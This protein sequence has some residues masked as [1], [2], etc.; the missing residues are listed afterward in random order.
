MWR[1]TARL[2]ARL[3]LLVLLV[4]PAAVRAHQPEAIGDLV[5]A[6]GFDRATTWPGGANY[7]WY[8]L[9]T[10]GDSCERGTYSLLPNFHLPG[11]RNEVQSQL[12]AMYAN[13]MRSLSL[14]IYF[15]DGVRHGSVIDADDPTQVAQAAQNLAILLLDVETTGFDRVTFRFFPQGNM[16]PASE[17][18]VPATTAKYWDLIVAMRP[19]LVAS[20][21]DYLIDLMV[22]GAPR[23]IDENWIPDVWM[24]PD[25]IEWSNAVRFLWRQYSSAYGA[26]DTVGFSF[27]TSFGSARA[28]VRHMPYVYEGVYPDTFAFDFYGHDAGGSFFSEA[29]LFLNMENL[30]GDYGHDGSSWIITETFHND[31]LAAA[32]LGSAIAATGQEVLYLTEWP[33]DRGAS[34]DAVSVPPPYQY[35]VWSMYGF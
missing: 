8:G 14:G 3:A 33:L 35:D 12:A 25:N 13:G 21:M 17:W 2:S 22:E 11:V 5:F 23:D 4:L 30:M 31:P 6:S 1:A 15:H 24:Y 27:L 7:L 9:G 18:F 20:N 26:A 29:E 32:G 10:P 34:C 16:N 19:A 28:R